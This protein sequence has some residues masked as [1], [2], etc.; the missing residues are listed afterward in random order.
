MGISQ[1]KSSN[2]KHQPYHT[3]MVKLLLNSETPNATF[4]YE[5]SSGDMGAGVSSTLLI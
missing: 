3:K 4:H 1:M 5:I 2:V